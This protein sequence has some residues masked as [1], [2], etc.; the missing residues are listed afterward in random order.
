MRSTT[1]VRKLHTV[2]LPANTNKGSTPHWLRGNTETIKCKSGYIYYLLGCKLLFTIN[3]LWYTDGTQFLL[4]VINLGNTNY[5]P[6][7]AL[8]FYSSKMPFSKVNRNDSPNRKL[9][10]FRLS[11]YVLV[12]LSLFT[13]PQYFL[14]IS[15]QA[16]CT[17]C[18]RN[19]ERRKDKNRF[20][21]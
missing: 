8:V 20:H 12:K 21:L 19:I 17:W 9:G 3:L 2:R 13:F 6:L 14:L 18:C 7:Y 15:F 10:C 16:A 5:N 4:E 1:H 11:F